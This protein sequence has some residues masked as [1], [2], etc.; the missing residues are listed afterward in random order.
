L[1]EHWRMREMIRIL[2]GNNR[3]TRDIIDELNRPSQLE[4]T[5][6]RNVVCGILE[7]IKKEGDRALLEYTNR[8]DGTDYRAIDEIIVS[9]DE[10]KQAYTFVSPGLLNA[11]ELSV[12]NI[13]RYHERQLQN[14]WVTFETDGVMLGQRIT[15]LGKVGIYV[16]GGRAS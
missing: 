6:K 7:D 15:P 12:E 2:D 4:Y 14:S 11:M 9:K 13:R 3:K 1:K 5:E 16:P 10:I 8:F